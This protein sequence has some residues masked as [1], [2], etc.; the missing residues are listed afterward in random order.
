MAEEEQVADDVLAERGRA[1]DDQDVLFGALEERFRPRAG[2]DAIGLELD[3]VE[4]A[5]LVVQARQRVGSE[6]HISSTRAKA[7][8]TARS[9][10]YGLRSAMRDAAASDGL[11]SRSRA[12][13]AADA[14]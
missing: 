6:L 12:H 13:D 11:D 2:Q 5:R 3:P 14:T 7:I 8:R 4:R 1:A 9:E 10:P